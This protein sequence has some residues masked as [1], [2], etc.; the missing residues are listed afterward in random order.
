MEAN[1]RPG[2]VLIPLGNKGAAAICFYTQQL[3]RQ[4]YFA[5][6]IAGL[7]YIQAALIVQGSGGGEAKPLGQGTDAVALRQQY[8][9]RIKG[10]GLGLV[11]QLSAPLGG[12]YTVAALQTKK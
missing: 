1:A 3:G 2:T 11:A 7:Y 5:I 9:G 8:V 10:T 4:K 12:N 6:G